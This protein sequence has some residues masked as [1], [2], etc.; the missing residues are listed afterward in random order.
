VSCGNPHETPCS[1]V[2]DAVFTFLD[3]EC[4]DRQRARIKQHL[5]ECSPCLRQF[6]IEDEVKE[7]VHRKCGGDRAPDSLKSRVR[8]R[9]TEIV[10]TETS[11]TIEGSPD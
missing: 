1:E 6:G 8:L 5:D 7:L 4:D 10:V 3:N 9:L 11:A 2:L